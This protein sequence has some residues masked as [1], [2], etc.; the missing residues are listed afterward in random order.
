M[1]FA[2]FW[3]PCPGVGC[4]SGHRGQALSWQH[5]NCGG[6]LYISDQGMLWC[7]CCNLQRLLVFWSF[8]CGRH[9]GVYMSTNIGVVATCY[10]NAVNYYTGEMGIIWI[11]NL[12]NNLNEMFSTYS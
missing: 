7:N 5:A 3:F 1:G 11:Q 9:A 12:L 8:A 6:Q 2:K 10:A 4:P